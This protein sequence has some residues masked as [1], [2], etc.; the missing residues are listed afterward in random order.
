MK[1]AAPPAPTSDDDDKPH[2][3]CGLF[4]IYGSPDAAAHA[5]LVATR[6]TRP[7]QVVGLAVAAAIPAVLLVWWASGRIDRGFPYSTWYLMETTV[8]GARGIVGPVLAAAILVVVWSLGSLVMSRVRRALVAAG[9]YRPVPTEDERLA[10]R[11][12]RPLPSF[13]RRRGDARATDHEPVGRPCWRA[14]G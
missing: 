1:P 9:P 5:A 6:A 10:R 12:R 4:G 8:S 2:E 7:W 14:T 11:G 3:E 13:G